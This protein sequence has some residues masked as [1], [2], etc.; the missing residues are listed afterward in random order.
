M[1]CT[2][3]NGKESWIFTWRKFIGDTPVI[4]GQIILTDEPEESMVIVTPFNKKAH[5]YY[6]QKINCMRAEGTVTV[7]RKYFIFSPSDSFAVLD[8]EAGVWTYKNTWY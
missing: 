1:K 6:N 7:N 5:F 3:R 4:R 2:N 8:W